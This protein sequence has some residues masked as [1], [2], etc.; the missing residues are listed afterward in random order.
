VRRAHPA[1]V[2]LPRAGV[3]PGRA[4]RCS[5]GSR[6]VRAL[7]IPKPPPAVFARTGSRLARTL[8]V[9]TPTSATSRRCSSRTTR[10]VK[11]GGHDCGERGRDLERRR[12]AVDSAEQRHPRVGD[13]LASGA[14]VRVRD[15]EHRAC[16]SV[17]ESF[18][19]RRH[20]TPAGSRNSTRSPGSRHCGSPPLCA[21]LSHEPRVHSSRRSGSGAHSSGPWGE[22]GKRPFRRS[23]SARGLGTT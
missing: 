17:R 14:G 8:A 12:G 20:V 3:R 10:R 7:S 22:L 9:H 19:K 2:V 23:N 1:D 18:G 5:G 4:R 11:T 13:G 16:L 15:G 21:K 6:A